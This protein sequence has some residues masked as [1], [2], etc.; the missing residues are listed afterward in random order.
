MKTTSIDKYMYLSNLRNTNTDLFYRLLIDNMRV[1]GHPPVS[2][3]RLKLLRLSSNV[4]YCSAKWGYVDPW[5]HQS[6]R[7]GLT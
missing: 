1:S 4:T 6:D 3:P 7:W 2:L 5:L